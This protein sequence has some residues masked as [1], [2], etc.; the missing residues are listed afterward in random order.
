MSAL[1]AVLDEVFHGFA[2]ALPHSTPHKKN[3][4]RHDW[5]VSAVGRDWDIDVELEPAQNG[6]RTDPSWDA[7]VEVTGI[8]VPGCQD[9]LTEYLDDTVKEAIEEAAYDYLLEG[10]LP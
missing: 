2:P 3:A 6:G 4:W 9:D 7:S 8:Y 5:T 10:D 1:P